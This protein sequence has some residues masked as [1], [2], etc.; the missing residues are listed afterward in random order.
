V[1]NAQKQKKKDSNNVLYAETKATQTVLNVQKQ[2][3]EDFYYVLNAMKKK[4]QNVAN[5]ATVQ[6][7]CIGAMIY[8]ENV[9]IVRIFLKILHPSPL[10]SKNTICFYIPNLFDCLFF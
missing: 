1:S 9:F 2:M 10:F 5:N 4:R 3:K 8:M 7:K 6:V